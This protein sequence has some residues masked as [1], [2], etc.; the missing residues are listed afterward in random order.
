MKPSFFSF[1]QYPLVLKRCKT[2]PATLLAMPDYACEGWW[3]RVAM[4]ACSV[5]PCHHISSFFVYLKKY[6]EVLNMVAGWQKLC[7]R[8][9]GAIIRTCYELKIAEPHDHVTGAMRIG[10]ILHV[11]PMVLATPM[12]SNETSIDYRYRLEA[13]TEVSI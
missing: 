7:F 3:Q 4:P 1:Y 10:K 6:H 11:S 9:P 8:R 13:F 12:A 5:P 2:V